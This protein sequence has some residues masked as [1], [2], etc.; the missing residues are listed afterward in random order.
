MISGTTIA[1]GVLAKGALTV[2]LLSGG[3]E[4]YFLGCDCMGADSDYKPTEPE[5]P[6]FDRRQYWTS[7][8][9]GFTVATIL[10][11]GGAFIVHTGR[12]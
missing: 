9:A 3:H 7:V 11:V 5:L 4:D 8:A 10:A 1:L 12:R 2:G 6:F